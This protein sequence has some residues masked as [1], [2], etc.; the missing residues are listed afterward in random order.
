MADLVLCRAGSTTIAE[1]TAL[2]IP[3]IIIPY[4]FATGNHQELNARILEKAGAAEVVLEKDLTDKVL[5]DILKRVIEN[6][7]YRK[8]MGQESKKLG[9]VSAVEKI[10]QDI[11][12]LARV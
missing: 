3:A 5:G 7:K 6:E 2:G 4:P 1:I 10:T 8:K 12:E 11:L 9:N